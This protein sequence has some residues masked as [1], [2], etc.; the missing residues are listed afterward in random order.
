LDEDLITNLAQTHKLL[1]TV[2][3]NAIA[4]GAGSAVSEYLVKTNLKID[5][6]Q[7][8][9]KDQFVKQGTCQQL[10]KLY[11]L[12]ENGIELQI[13]QKLAVLNLD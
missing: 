4:G 3:E 11:Q 9:L 6:L 5:I 13:R 1:V 2:E 10:L 8:G 7:I 12:D